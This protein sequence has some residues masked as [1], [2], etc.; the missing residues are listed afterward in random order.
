MDKLSLKIKAELE[1][2]ED[3]AIVGLKVAEINNA[4][5]LS[6]INEKNE[7]TERIFNL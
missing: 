2:I 1:N 7:V 4:I 3:G 5:I 6:I